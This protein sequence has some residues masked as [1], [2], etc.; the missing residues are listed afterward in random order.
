M[1]S[2]VFCFVLTFIPGVCFANTI[3]NG[4][5]ETGDFT[6][7]EVL[8]DASIQDAAFGINPAEGTYNSLITT[9]CDATISDK[10]NTSLREIPISG[11]NAVSHNSDYFDFIGVDGI[12]N[13]QRFQRLH[14]SLIN[15][16]PGTHF[17]TGEGSAIRQRFFAETGDVLSFDYNVL[18]EEG[19]LRDYDFAFAI[20]SSDVLPSAL[21]FDLSTWHVLSPSNAELDPIRSDL[22]TQQTG[23]NK[24]EY[25]FSAPGTYTLALTLLE[26]VEGTVASGLLVDNVKLTQQV[27][28]P[29]TLS[30][31]VLG[32]MMMFSK[33][34]HNLLEKLMTHRSTKRGQL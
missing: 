3:T 16:P 19:S 10:C 26:T 20:I 22:D 11:T 31:F 15:P 27:P 25:D 12:D 14:D 21:I 28:A 5:F 9:L 1:K 7:W 8:G 34:K 2:R 4:G 18:T 33:A 32:I 29:P 13:E 24:F 17:P 30:L 23:F 6:G